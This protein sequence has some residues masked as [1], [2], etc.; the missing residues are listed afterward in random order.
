MA[1][2]R[3]MRWQKVKKSKRQATKKKTGNIKITEMEPRLVVKKCCFVASCVL[4]KR[5][6]T[7]YLHVEAEW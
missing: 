5:T 1:I 2:L 4:Y 6:T 7:I 3:A